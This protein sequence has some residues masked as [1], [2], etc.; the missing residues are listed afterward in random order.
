MTVA[1]GVNHAPHGIALLRPQVQDA[2]PLAGNRILRAGKVEQHF[3]VLDSHRLLR[4]GQKLL[5]HLSE[6]FG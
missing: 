4:A 6:E 3:A 1:L 2:L 5:H